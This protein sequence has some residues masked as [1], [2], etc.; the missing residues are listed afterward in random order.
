[1]NGWASESFASKVVYYLCKCFE[2]TQSKR[3]SHHNVIILIL[4]SGSVLFFLLYSVHLL[5]RSLTKQ[6]Y[7]YFDLLLFS[8]FYSLVSFSNSPADFVIEFLIIDIAVVLVMYFRRVFFV[9]WFFFLI[10]FRLIFNLCF[11]YLSLSLCIFPFVSCFASSFHWFHCVCNDIHS[12]TVHQC[13][14]SP[15]STLNFHHSS[16]RHIMSIR[17]VSFYFNSLLRT[18]C[19]SIHSSF[20][21]IHSFLF[22]FIHHPSNPFTSIVNR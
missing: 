16:H 14:I 8:F 7:D 12:I 21:S 5:A 2:C 20:F 17:A 3:L 13:A 22:D 1:M 4:D 11:V 10:N 15:S 19:F 9:I 18:L 6:K